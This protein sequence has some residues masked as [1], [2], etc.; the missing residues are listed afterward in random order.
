M[1]STN[2][3]VLS[4][5]AALL[6]AGC[7][8]TA[9]NNA[10]DAGSGGSHD[11][12]S[13]SGASSGGSDS[14][15]SSSGSDSG[16]SSSGSDSGGSS[17]GSDSGGSQDSG[18]T[19][20]GFC[21]TSTN[22]A[23]GYTAVALACGQKT[24]SGIAVHNGVVY[25]TNY[26]AGGEVMSVPEAGGTPTIIATNQD[27]PWAIAVDDSNV[28]WTNY[29]NGYGP[30]AGGSTTSGTVMKVPLTG[31]TPVTLAQGLQNPW[32]I[33][34]DATNVYF[35]N[36]GGGTI[37]SVP[38]AGGNVTVLAS[39]LLQP[40]GIAVQNGVVYWVNYAGTTVNNNFYVESVA[41][42]GGTPKVLSSST[43]A[44]EGFGLAVNATSIFLS[45]EQGAVGAATDG[46]LS[47]PLAGSSAPTVLAS[48]EVTP[49]AIALDATN[50]YW[51][52]NYVNNGMVSSMPLAGGT[53]TRL[54][55]NLTNPTGIAVDATGVYYTAAGGGRVWRLTPP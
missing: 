25:W 18:A 41:T 22:T 7:S 36:A 15:G 29:D 43:D 21:L 51:T 1:R 5:S 10:S 13:S 19:D 34:L 23:P 46:L 17:S 11:S 42:T 9:T 3:L 16:G 4:G 54:A 48:A 28:Y 39:G 47:M 8:F 38:I 37:K 27:F 30:S 55:T 49:F 50:V 52:S 33:A 6:A 26:V 35:S 31:G 40:E 14:G 12:G 53:P 32:G 45:T 20:G 44:F 2:I 24:P